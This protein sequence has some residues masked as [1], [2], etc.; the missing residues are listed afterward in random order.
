[1][2]LIEFQPTVKNG[3][4]EIPPEYHEVGLYALIEG[5][6]PENS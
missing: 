5:S 4:I 1:M 2:E 3:V 6:E